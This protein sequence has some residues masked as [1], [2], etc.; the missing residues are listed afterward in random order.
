[1]AMLNSQMVNQYQSACS[2]GF[3]PFFDCPEA[4]LSAWW[5]FRRQPGLTNCSG[6]SWIAA[7]TMGI[8]IYTIYIFNSNN[9]NSNNNDNNNNDSNNDNNNSN[10]NNNK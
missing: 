10:N 2:Y 1:M 6:K 8:Y 4:W 7:E 5:L 9:N 3:H